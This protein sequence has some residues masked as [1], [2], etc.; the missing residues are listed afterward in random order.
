MV[1][2]SAV[3]ERLQ[4]QIP[5]LEQQADAVE[6][7]EFVGCQAHGVHALKRDRN[8]AHG[9]GGV[10]MQVAVR[11]L[12]QDLGNLLHWL[13]HAQLTVHHRDRHDNGVRAKQL[14]EMVQVNGAVPLDVYQV[15]LITLLLQSG[16]GA[17]DR[18]V[19]QR[20]RDDMLAHMAGEPGQPLEGKVGWT[21]W[22]RRCR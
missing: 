17:A 8:F 14:F 6:T 1:V 13:H 15:D 11:V 18:R 5:P 19:L 20:G 10:H 22:H 12:F 16:Q 3:D 2:L 4:R 7:I 9:L 21:R